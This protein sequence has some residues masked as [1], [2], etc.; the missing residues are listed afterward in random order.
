M[1]G[2]H[3]LDADLL[4][5]LQH[6]GERVS[7]RLELDERR[8]DAAG[9]RTF[10]GLDEIAAAAADAMHFLGQVDRAEPHGE[11]TREVARDLRRPAAQL[12]AELGRGFLVAGPAANR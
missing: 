2:E 3:R 11:R 10:A 7:A 12:D 6:L 1:R 9:L 8:F 5:Q 4:Q